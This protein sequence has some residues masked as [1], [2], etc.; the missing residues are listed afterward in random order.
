M[1]LFQKLSLAGFALLFT[2]IA[3]L[4]PGPAQAIVLFDRVINQ[5]NDPELNIAFAQEA[6]ARGEL[7][8]ALGA[9]ERLLHDNPNNARAR[10]EFNRL[11]IA[12]SPA[13]TSVHSSVSIRGH[14]GMSPSS[15]DS[16]QRA[17][18]G[19]LDSSFSLRDD[20]SLSGLR[21]RTDINSNSRIHAKFDEIDEFS[22]GGVTG[23]VFQ[24]R[25]G[26]KLHVAGGG[27]ALFLDNSLF[28]S[29]ATSRL[30]LDFSSWWH[31]PDCNRNHWPASSGEMTSF[32]P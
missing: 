30:T 2:L 18:E 15:T 9:Y 23:P 13:T 16:N 25:E 4:Q 3:I 11:R 8:H 10:Q 32:S 29:Q 19:T 31:A 14:S 24:L 6:E 1:L 5:P 7:R 17:R 21:W 26:V 12:L 28:Y 20:R 27:G 22:I